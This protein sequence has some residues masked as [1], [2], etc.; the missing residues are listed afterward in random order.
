MQEMNGKKIQRFVSVP[1]TDV[2]YPET[3]ILGTLQDGVA[4]VRQ[5]PRVLPGGFYEDAPV[6]GLWYP[7]K[8]VGDRVK[9]GE[10]LGQIR[11]VFGQ[12]LFS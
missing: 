6:S 8:K 5:N 1:Q 11:D 4:A 2:T 12:V 7:R 9:K 10:E 3:V